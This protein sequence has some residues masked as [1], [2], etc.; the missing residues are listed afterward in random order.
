VPQA[1][2]LITDR[3]PDA[4]ILDVSLG[5]ENCYP[6]ADFFKARGIPFAFGTGG[7]EQTI[8]ARHADAPILSKPYSAEA[9]RS[10]L[11]ALLPPGDSSG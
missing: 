11:S 1:L 10:V 3:P 5:K 8:A 9:L 2:S 4:A 7:N 6:V